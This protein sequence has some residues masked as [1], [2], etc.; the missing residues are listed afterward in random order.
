MKN[1][2]ENKLNTE[3]HVKQILDTVLSFASLNFDSRAEIKG[4]SDQLDALAEGINML[5][6]ELKVKFIQINECENVIREVHHRV[7]NNLQLV[8]SILNLQVQVIQ[9]K[10][11][12]AKLMDCRE[13]IS[14]MALVHEQLYRAEDV[15]KLEINTYFGSLCNR[16]EHIHSHETVSLK[17]ISAEK[18]FFLPVDQ[19]IPMGLL[20]NELI[21]NSY[22]HAFEENNTG[23][24]LFQIVVEKEKITFELTDN[25]IGFSNPNDFYNSPTLGLQLVHSLIDQLGAEIE[26]SNQN[27]YRVILKLTVKEVS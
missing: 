10:N 21:V 27:P 26:F 19:I 1:Y 14:S 2:P 20:I 23:L 25:G 15:T 16:L 24:I 6:E 4:E 5:G 12:Q 3:K 8:S 22:K 17:F 11:L 9:D 18:S 13:R 7:K